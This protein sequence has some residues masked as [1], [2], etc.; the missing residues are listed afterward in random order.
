MTKENQNLESRIAI[1]VEFELRES[2][3]TGLAK[4][5]ARASIAEMQK[6]LPSPLAVAQ[7]IAQFDF[8]NASSKTGQEARNKSIRIHSLYKE[9]MGI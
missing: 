2:Q 8:D 9:M 1:A 3:S 4:R 7:I 5:I 6:G